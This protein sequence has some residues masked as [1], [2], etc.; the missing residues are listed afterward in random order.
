MPI[1]KREAYTLRLPASYQR[2]ASRH[3]RI[4]V[5]VKKAKKQ[6]DAVFDAATAVRMLEDPAPANSALL[7]I[8]ALD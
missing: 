4:D 2:I 1:G 6:S 3:F 8:L 7:E 5:P